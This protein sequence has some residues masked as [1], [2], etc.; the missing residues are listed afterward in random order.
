[1]KPK[2]KALHKALSNSAK[3][4]RVVASGSG[5]GPASLAPEPPPKLAKSGRPIK[6]PG[7]Y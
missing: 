7:K 1:N 4:R 5:K 3:K 2:R 6:L